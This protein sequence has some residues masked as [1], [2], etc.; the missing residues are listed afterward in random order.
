MKTASFF[1]Y[2]MWV[3]TKRIYEAHGKIVIIII[4]YES[5][6]RTSAGTSQNTSILRTSFL[7]GVH[8][9]RTVDE[10][11]SSMCYHV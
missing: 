7:F 2:Y 3:Y 8:N 5:Y 9:K 6:I 1:K 10:G 11:L 4:F